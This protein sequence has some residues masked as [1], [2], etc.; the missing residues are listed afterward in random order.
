MRRLLLSLVGF[1]CAFTAFSQETVLAFRVTRNGKATGIADVRSR[2]R[3][4]GRPGVLIETSRQSS[5]AVGAEVQGV[6]QTS[7]TWLDE[8]NDTERI[9]VCATS[10]GRVHRVTA[11]PSGGFLRIEV[12]NS[13]FKS[14]LTSALPADTLL[15]G[16]VNAC[17]PLLEGGLP[18]PKVATLNSTSLRLTVSPVIDLGLSKQRIAGSAEIVRELSL[19]DS[20]SQSTLLMDTD[21]AVVGLRKDGEVYSPSLVSPIEPDTPEP[22]EPMDYGLESSMVLTDARDIR[23]LRIQIQGGELPS[24]LADRFL[25][26]EN[27]PDGA[28]VTVTRHAGRSTRAK[29]LGSFDR[30]T[31]Q[32]E[33]SP[34]PLLPSE[35]PKLKDLAKKVVGDETNSLL[36]ARRL[37]KWVSENIK[38]NR[39]I[40]VP[41]NALEILESREGVCRDAATLLTTLTRSIGIPSRMVGGLVYVDKFRFHAW[42]E[43]YTGSEWV[44]LDA[45]FAEAIPDATHIKLA[46]GNFGEALRLPTFGGAKITVELVRY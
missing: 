38:V 20:D 39:K 37:R 14:Q 8:Y 18:Y 7:R 16:D 33:L 42:M 10:A 1:A 41:R 29:S 2:P 34:E 36:A 30:A 13:G 27:R 11:T 15:L 17:I 9:E 23:E 22:V 25:Q 45:A 6:L 3:P 5:L 40:G 46:C 19:R 4:D 44:P 28:C 31:F 24:S 12:E 26:V 32:K 35:E 43:V 21:G